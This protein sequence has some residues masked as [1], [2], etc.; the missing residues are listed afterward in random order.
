MLTI[1]SLLFTPATKIAKLDRALDSGA[2]WVV[3]DLED[4]VGPADKPSARDALGA[5]SAAGFAAAPD[6]IALRINSLCGIDGVHDLAA[7]AGWPSWP[8]M[9]VVPKVESGRELEQIAAIAR[10]RGSTPALFATI[11]SARGLERAADILAEAP[12]VAAI[13]YGSADHCAE[14]GGTMD[15]DALLWARGRIVNAAATK[16][17][18]AVD[19]AWLDIRDADGLAAEAAA[20]A[21][22]GFAGKVAI[23]PGQV[24]IV[25][26]A[27]TP[28]SDAAAEARAVLAASAQSGGG[29]FALD[30]RMI[31]APVLRRAQRIAAAAANRPG[32]RE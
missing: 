25:N 15:W 32:E 5:L 21:R 6:R 9:I 19:G 12:L 11:E 14:T 7:M 29:A 31:D 2:D 8:A 26:D 17:I 13:G 24:G 20:V 4:G 30:G 10:H 22:L 16:G 3:L 28:S 23:H 18:P 1:R 27:F